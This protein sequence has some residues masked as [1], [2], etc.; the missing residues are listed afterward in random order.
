MVTQ[1]RPP[2]LEGKV[3]MEGEMDGLHEIGSA[4]PQDRIFTRALL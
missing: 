4:N 3:P 2:M 1:V